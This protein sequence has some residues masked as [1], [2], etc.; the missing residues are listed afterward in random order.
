MGFIPW[1]PS[2]WSSLVSHFA[3]QRLIQSNPL[4]PKIPP[5]STESEMI[6]KKPWEP[7]DSGRI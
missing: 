6:H 2:F 3:K 4:I 5:K 1:M 7:G